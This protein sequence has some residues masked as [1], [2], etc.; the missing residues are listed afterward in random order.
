MT[1][2]QLKQLIREEIDSIKESN[3]KSAKDAMEYLKNL[4]SNGD[5][6]ND[7][8]N[9]FYKDLQSASRKS[10]VDADKYMAANRKKTAQ[11]DAENE[12]R[13]NNNLLPFRATIAPVSPTSYD[14]PQSQ[15]YRYSH[16]TSGD[17]RV[18]KLKPEYENK[19]V[20][21][22]LAVFYWKGYTGDVPK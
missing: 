12:E 6:N 2:A 20:P 1:K 9:S 15:F 3:I 16:T 7:D 22:H 10:K 13:K 4:A 8:I 21:K 17:Y 18:Y 5:I 19:P 11:T 14:V